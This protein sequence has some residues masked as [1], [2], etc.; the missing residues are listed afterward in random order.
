MK[1]LAEIEGEKETVSF[2]NVY[3]KELDQSWVAR[4]EQKHEGAPKFLSL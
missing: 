2:V 1:V 4:E 3:D